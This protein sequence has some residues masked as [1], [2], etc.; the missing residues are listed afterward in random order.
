M[1]TTAAEIIPQD[2]EETILKINKALAKD[3]EEDGGFNPF[4]I[5]FTKEGKGMVAPDEIS[6]DMFDPEK[7]GIFSAKIKAFI[8]AMKTVE[9]LDVTGTLIGQ[10]IYY[11]QKDKDNYDPESYEPGDLSKDPDS[12][13]AVM[14]LYETKDYVVNRLYRA[15]YSDDKSTAVVSEE[16]TEEQIMD[17]N[18]DD[19]FT[20]ESW[21][22]GH[23]N[24]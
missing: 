6:Q 22:I 9:G 14:L 21:M 7:K 18:S 12:E 20:M 5:F 1:N 11:A 4:I 17:K 3:I 19:G 8:K 23:L 2:L 13:E 24:K 16:P 15:I 10:N